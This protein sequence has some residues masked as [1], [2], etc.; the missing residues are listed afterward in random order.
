MSP[1]SQALERKEGKYHDVKDQ[2][3][4]QSKPEIEKKYY[5]LQALYYNA[6]LACFNVNHIW[7]DIFWLWGGGGRERLYIRGLSVIQFFNTWLQHNYRPQQYD[8][9]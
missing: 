5:H 2:H 3:R 6:F 8:D 9:Q 7:C 4:E 1:S